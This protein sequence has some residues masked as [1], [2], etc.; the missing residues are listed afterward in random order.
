[1]TVLSRNEGSD[2]S[3]SDAAE[4]LLAYAISIAE[5]GSAAV[6]RHEYAAAHTR[7]FEDPIARRVASRKLL[8]LRTP[9]LLWGH[10]RGVATGSGSWALRRGAAHELIAPIIDALFGGTGS[11]TDQLVTGATIRLNSESSG[12]LGTRPSPAVT[13]TP[14]ARSPWHARCSNRP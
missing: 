5:G 12:T 1:M 13:A 4:A 8:R 7:L 14:T 11:P 6:T 10:L 3:A 9:E 2:W